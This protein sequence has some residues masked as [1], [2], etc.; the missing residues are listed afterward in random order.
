MLG[1]YFFS[2]LAATLYCT[3]DDGVDEAALA[4]AAERTSGAEFLRREINNSFGRPGRGI[5]FLYYFFFFFYVCPR[6]PAARPRPNDHD[7]CAETN[8]IILYKL[9]TPCTINHNIIYHHC[10]RTR[11]NNRG[12]EFAV[13]ITGDN[14]DNNHLYRVIITCVPRRRRVIVLRCY[15]DCPH[16]RGFSAR[17]SDDQRHSDLHHLC[18]LG[19]SVSHTVLFYDCVYRPLGRH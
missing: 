5:L 4:W 17:R 1:V 16:R 3:V 6:Y 15:N 12:A 14:D 18:V 19:Y 11:S 9:A 10:R 2:L 13:T 8:G 7:D